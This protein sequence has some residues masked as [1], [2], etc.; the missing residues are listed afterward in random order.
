MNCMDTWH[1]LYL[2][3]GLFSSR[4][5]EK[6]VVLRTFRCCPFDCSPGVPGGVREGRFPFSLAWD[7]SRTPICVDGS[8]SGTVS[9]KPTRRF[10][11]SVIS[12]PSFVLALI[13]DGHDGWRSVRWLEMLYFQW[14]SGHSVHLIGTLVHGFDNEVFDA[15]A[16]LN[17]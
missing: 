14:I 16:M 17:V 12:Q 8:V 5:D 3:N 2:T 4:I 1:V 13:C 7:G 10:S 9:V 15:A 11:S 6:R